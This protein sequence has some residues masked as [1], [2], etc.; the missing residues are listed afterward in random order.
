MI[1][2][3]AAMAAPAGQRS[4]PMAPG[5]GD[6]VERQ[7]ADGRRHRRASLASRGWMTEG[8]MSSYS[9]PGMADALL[10][11]PVAPGADR[12]RGEPL[13]RARRRHQHHAAD[14]P[15]AGLRGDPPRAQPVGRR[16]RHRGGA[17]GRAGRGGVV[18]PGRPRRVLPL[19]RR[20]A[21]RRGR[22]E[23]ARVRRRR[24]RDRGERDRGARGLRRDE[25]LLAGR[26]AAHGARA[27][28]Q[29]DRVGLRRRSGQPTRW[30]RSTTCWRATT[31]RSPGPSPPW[32]SAP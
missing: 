11:V 12:H 5:L 4:L 30:R 1:E 22:G 28:D 18:L 3:A 16:D 9:G 2:V 7:R 8:R 23:R 13:R 32:R 19:P 6:G 20:P 27:D 31:A 29:H 24:R 17:G 10:H 26:R 14:P 15:V 21:A 25:D